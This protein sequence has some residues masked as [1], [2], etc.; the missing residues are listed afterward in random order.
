MKMQHSRFFGLPFNY[1]QL[2]VFICK[3][4]EPVAESRK[5]NG[6]SLTAGEFH[7]RY[8]MLGRRLLF[9]VEHFDWLMIDASRIGD[10]LKTY[11]TLNFITNNIVSENS[12]LPFEHFAL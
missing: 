4:R 7:G 2:V 11:F 1:E 12:C 10:W 5:Q 3:D 6:L 8:D 9:S